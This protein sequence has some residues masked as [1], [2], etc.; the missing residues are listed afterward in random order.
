M[1]RRA[2]FSN[3][4]AFRAAP[5][6]A[7]TTS[8]VLRS[9]QRAVAP[10]AFRMGATRWYSAEAK[11]EVKEKEAEKEKEAAPQENGEVVELKK[12]LETKDKEVVDLKDK[13]LRLLAEFRT[14]QDR[15]ARDQK[16]AKTY[17]VQKF[18]SDLL[19]SLDNFD[20]ALAGVPAEALH[21]SKAEEQAHLQALVEG[22]KMTESVLAQTLAQHGIE[23]VET[24]VGS[25]F[26][27]ST[28]EVTVIVPQAEGEDGI[29]IAVESKGYQLNGRLLRPSKVIVSKKA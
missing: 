17:A 6:A 19:E 28:H 13:Y 15:S 18:A 12:K 11:D 14:L 23:K 9:Q 2:I 1:L 5:V 3:A 16:S 10:A 25:K 7:R 26:D 24:E 21:E 22:L 8:A 20:R 4:R 27:A 29:I